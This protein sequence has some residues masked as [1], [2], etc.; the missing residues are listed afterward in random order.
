MLQRNMLLSLVKAWKTLKCVCL[1]R[2]SQFEKSTYF[3]NPPK[4][5]TVSKRQ[6]QNKL[7]GDN[8]KGPVSYQPWDDG[9]V[10][11]I[12]NTEDF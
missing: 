3:M 8:R 1:S 5:V 12:N 11:T 4:Y 6:K 10:R 9:E 2:R 7:C